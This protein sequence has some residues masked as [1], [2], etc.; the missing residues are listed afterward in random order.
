MSTWKK[1]AIGAIV[2]VLL[3]SMIGFTVY[4]SHKNVVVVQTAKAKT[5][6]LVSV[7]SASGK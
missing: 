1:I 6:D 7:V 3:A 2:V 5:M 4:R